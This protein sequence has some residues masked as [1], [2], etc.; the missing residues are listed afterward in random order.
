MLC[1]MSLI[2]C[3]GVLDRQIGSNKYKPLELDT[4][5]QLLSSSLPLG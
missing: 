3:G 4:L 2:R 1:G 5:A